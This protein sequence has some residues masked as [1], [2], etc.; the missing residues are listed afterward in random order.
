MSLTIDVHHHILPDFFWRATNEQH[1]PVGGIAPAH[2]SPEG[3][4]GFMDDAKIDVALTWATDALRLYSG[5]YSGA[6]PLSFFIQR[7]HRTPHSIS[8]DY[9][10]RCSISPWIHPEPSR[11]FITA[12][13]SHVRPM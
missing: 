3:A 5:S 2:W 10:T 13:P 7:P 12:T 6:R 9:P 1:G 4:I 8:W 11:T